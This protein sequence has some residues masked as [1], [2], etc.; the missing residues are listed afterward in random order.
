MLGGRDRIARPSHFNLYNL[1][2]SFPYNSFRNSISS[3]LL[4]QVYTLAQHRMQLRMLWTAELPLCFADG[5][6]EN[7]VFSVEVHDPVL[8]VELPLVTGPTNLVPLAHNNVG[9]KA[10]KDCYSR[11]RDLYFK[12]SAKKLKSQVF[13]GTTREGSNIFLKKN[14]DFWLQNSTNW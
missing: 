8:E 3:S 2:I 6:L 14:H 9:W 1:N 5:F 12:T 10:K 13:V 11:Y 7:V 4:R